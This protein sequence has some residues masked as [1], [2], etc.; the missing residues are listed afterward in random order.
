MGKSQDEQFD[1]FDKFIKYLFLSVIDTFTM[2]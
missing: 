2:I 1:E